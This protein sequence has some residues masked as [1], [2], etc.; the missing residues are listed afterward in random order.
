MPRPRKAQPDEPRKRVYVHGDKH[1][2]QTGTFYCYGCSAFQEVDHFTPDRHYVPMAELFE[3]SHC[4]ARKGLRRG[5]M[6]RPDGINSLQVP[7][8]TVHRFTRN[9]RGRY[10]YQSVLPGGKYADQRS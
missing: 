9:S 8:A 5:W 6:Y 7:W 4:Q 2:Q 10:R 1:E 3:M